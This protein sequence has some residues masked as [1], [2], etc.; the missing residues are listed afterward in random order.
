V[1]RGLTSLL[2]IRGLTK[3]FP[4]IR[5]LDGVSF[6]VS[7]GEIVALV[8]Q[9]GSGKS[10]LVKILAGV[11]APEAGTVTLP[12]RPS[13]DPGPALHFIH[14]DLGLVGSLNTIENLDLNRRLTWGD[15]RAASGRRDRDHAGRLVA[16]F[17]GKFDVTVPV[18]RLA[19]AERTI[20]AI[21]RALDSWTG[22]DNVLVLDE[23]TAALHAGEVHVLF[24]AVRR[25]AAEGAGVVFVSHRLDEVMDLADRAVVLR[26]G[27]LVAD[28]PAAELS[29]DRLVELIA[30]RPVSR[31]GRRAPTPRAPA[32]LTVRGLAGGT[33]RRVDLT[34]G[35]GEVLGVTGILGSGREHLGGLVFGSSRRTGGEVT[36][37]GVTLPPG[38]VRAAIARG[39]A[40]V[41]AE[42]HT[43]GAVMNLSVRENMTLPG[44]RNLTRPGGR[45]DR[46]TEQAEVRGWIGRV[47]LRPPDPETPM[48]NLSG[49]NQQ[50]AVM[51][52]WL[53]N[54]PDVLILDEPTQGVDVNGKEAIYRLIGEAAAAGKAVLV[55]SSDLEEMAAVCDRALVL[56]DGEVAAEVPGGQVTA[57]RLL[58]ES[59]GWAGPN[60]QAATPAGTGAGR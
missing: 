52:K 37:A 49:G 12:H 22:T 19:P 48:R 55:I 51:A 25:V 50:K 28:R 29:S 33:A 36:V 10:T 6:S 38:D 18:S 39:M 23:P 5:A 58:S 1:G 31:A 44:L 20:V 60:A 21:A 14:Q 16:R 8:G 53:R 15:V 4:G 47:Q 2:E 46:R 11:H 32:V 24:D 57:D 56:R 54:E 43:A 13:E 3:T 34:V 26:D 41:P 45:L 42:R 40:F 17:G 27:R 30:G 35:A 9:N 59:L 7:S